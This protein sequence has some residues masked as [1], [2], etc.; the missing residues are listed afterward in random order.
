MN[1][2]F[3]DDKLGEG[4]LEEMLLWIWLASVL[5]IT[6]PMAK[7][8]LWF[9]WV[10]GLLL[11]GMLMLEEDE[12]ATAAVEVVRYMFAVVAAVVTLDEMEAAWRGASCIMDCLCPV[13]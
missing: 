11:F 6:L 7:V 4:K 10:D 5:L 13:N 9:L 2:T 8:W 12:A 1:E 3:L